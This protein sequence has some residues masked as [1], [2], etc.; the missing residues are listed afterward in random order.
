MGLAPG[1]ELQRVTLAPGQRLLLY[2]DGLAEARDAKG[3]LFPLDHQVHAALRGPTPDAS[4]GRLLDL[5]SAH[6]GPTSADDL[7]LILAEPA[8]PPAAP[9]NPAPLPP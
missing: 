1:P 2:T 4:L 7:T 6:A 9:R 8:A 3:D 5:L